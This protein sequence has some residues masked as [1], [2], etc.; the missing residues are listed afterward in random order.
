MY[1]E[2]LDGTRTFA[3]E[4][5]LLRVAQARKRNGQCTVYR[6]AERNTPREYETS[7]IRAAADK[8]A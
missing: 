3:L 4:G 7:A 6:K 1:A 8:R 5:D 2:G